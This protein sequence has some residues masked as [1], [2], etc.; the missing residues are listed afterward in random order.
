MKHFFYLAFCV[1]ALTACTGGFKKGEKGLEYK[2]ISK[3]SGNKI[4]Y[5]DFIQLHIKQ[6]YSGTKDTVLYDSHEFMPRIQVFDSVKTP[7]EYF[8]VLRNMRKGDSLVIRLLTD[9]FISRT[10]D[11]MPP[12]MKKG[13]F[14]YTHLSLVNVFK[15]VTEAD[16]AN[17]AERIIMKPKLFKKQLEEM[18]NQ[19]TKDKDQMAKDDKIISDYLAKNNIQAQKT[20]W[21]T[22][23]AVHQEGTGDKINFNSVVMVNYTGKTLDSALVF[24]SNTDPKFQHTQPYEV[25]IWELGTMNSVIPGWTDALQQLKNG[26][27]AT[28]YIPSSLAYGSQGNGREIK[29]H[30]NLIF[31]IEIKEAVSE[32]V[33]MAKQQKMQ[34]EMM[35]K[36][37]QDEQARA[38]S[39]QKAAPQK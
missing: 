25:K 6:V 34:E 28:V 16:S 38:D 9:S 11:A 2:L 36:M 39:V 33:Y 37:Q 35:R 22:Y 27:K 20:K 31:D 14:M 29:P 1:L 5:G 10:G 26:A 18:G 32:E 12:Y 15:N 21:G 3:G 24:D 19:V 8:K 13:K 23:V 4:S 7:V 17:K 30:S